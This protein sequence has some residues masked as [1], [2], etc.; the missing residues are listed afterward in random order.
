MKFACNLTAEESAVLAVA[1][2][3]FALERQDWVG[4]TDGRPYYYVDTP[5]GWIGSMGNICHMGTVRAVFCVG[6]ET[7]SYGCKGTVTFEIRAGSISHAPGM[8]V[9]SIDKGEDW[10]PVVVE[11]EI[12]SVADLLAAHKLANEPTSGPKQ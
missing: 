8:V 9:E 2:F 11:G 1:P 10:E 7:D 4:V 12:N 6:Q 5:A 3:Q